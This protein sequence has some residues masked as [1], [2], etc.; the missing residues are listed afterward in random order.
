M[1]GLGYT[2]LVD[3]GVWSKHGRTDHANEAAVRSTKYQRSFDKIYWPA[4]RTR[5]PF[6]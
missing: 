5:N 3:G 2:V 4:Q 1:V 6:Y